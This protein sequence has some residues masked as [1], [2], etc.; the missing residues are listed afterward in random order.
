MSAA[1]RGW[2]DGSAVIQQVP[3]IYPGALRGKRIFRATAPR[4]C[5][6]SGRKCGSIFAFRGIFAGGALRAKAHFRATGGLGFGVAGGARGIGEMVRS[7]FERLGKWYK[8]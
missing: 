2:R 4:G 7:E 1:G 6:I 8:K 5:A 3:P